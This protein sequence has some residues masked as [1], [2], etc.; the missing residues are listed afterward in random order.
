ML[1]GV[2]GTNK[3]DTSADGVGE[4][5]SLSSVSQDDKRS[6]LFFSSAGKSCSKSFEPERIKSFHVKMMRT[7]GGDW[8]E[9]VLI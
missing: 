2:C 6:D 9:Q 1:F 3:T 4:I 8:F 7:R 5:S